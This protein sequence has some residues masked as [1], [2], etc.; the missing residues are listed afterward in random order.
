MWC[1]SQLCLAERVTDVSALTPRVL[2]IAHTSTP[3][4]LPC[5][6]WEQEEGMQMMEAEKASPGKY[7]KDPS[8]C[9]AEPCSREMWCVT[10]GMNSS[11]ASLRESGSVHGS[12]WISVGS[13]AFC[14]HPSTAQN[15]SLYPTDVHLFL[16][17]FLAL[18]QAGWRCKWEIEMVKCFRFFLLEK[19]AF[20]KFIYS[21]YTTKPHCLESCVY[22]QWLQH[23]V[24]T[25]VHGVTIPLLHFSAG[26]GGGSGFS[27]N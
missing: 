27:W 14:C 21:I 23:C 3:R 10:D 25:S 22:I 8:A 16:E 12:K 13:A 7:S 18:C 4:C 11:W 1:H 5:T 24:V 9:A 6:S 17:D 15:H 2:G 19:A 26:K 20:N